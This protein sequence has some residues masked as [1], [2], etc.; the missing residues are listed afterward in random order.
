MQLIR[1]LDIFDL[2]TDALINEIEL[3]EFHLENMIKYFDPPIE[4]NQMYMPYK[5]DEERKH[6]FPDIE[7]NFDKYEYFLACYSI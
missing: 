5:I 6:L 2:H 4:D 7:F 3:T 1:Q